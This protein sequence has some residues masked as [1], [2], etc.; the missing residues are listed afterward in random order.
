M[1]DLV[2]VELAKVGSVS[3]AFLSA[4]LASY[5][6]KK[7]EK[8]YKGAKKSKSETYNSFYYRAGIIR[9]TRAFARWNIFG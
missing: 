8:P 5:A 4:C 2:P 9:E 6:V 1:T 7:T 3:F